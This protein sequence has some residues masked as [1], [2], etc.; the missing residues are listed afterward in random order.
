MK[1]FLFLIL[2]SALTGC[3]D[4]KTKC[5][6]SV[7]SKVYAVAPEGEFP[8]PCTEVEAETVQRALVQSAFRKNGDLVQCMIQEAKVSCTYGYE[9]QDKAEFYYCITDHPAFEQI[10]IDQGVSIWTRGECP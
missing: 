4:L 6:G 2:A 5:E 1:K 10:G 7:P 8:M 3:L 9:P